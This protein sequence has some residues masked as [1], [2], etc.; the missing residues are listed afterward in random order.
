M[1]NFAREEREGGRMKLKRLNGFSGKGFM[2]LLVLTFT[3]IL[4][5]AVSGA[6]EPVVVWD[7]TYGGSGGD[8][9][10][11]IIETSN[12]CVVAGHTWSKGAGKIVW[13][14]YNTQRNFKINLKSNPVLIRETSL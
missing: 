1:V 6:T 13:L 7:R 14:S 11:S 10:E 8:W 9:A 12:G 2:R 3:L 4:L 5:I